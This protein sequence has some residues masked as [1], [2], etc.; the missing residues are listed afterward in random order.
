MKRRVLLA[1]LAVLLMGTS[2]AFADHHSHSH[3]VTVWGHGDGWSGDGGFSA[4]TLNGTYVFEASGF[5]NHAGPGQVSLL[6][7]L[8]FDGVSA[9]TGNF[10]VTA[11][12]GGQF[13]CPD[14]FTT[15]GSYTVAASSTAPGLGTLILPF[16]GGSN[17]G[18]INFGLLV[19]RSDGN[20]ADALETDTGSLSG[21]S[22]C[23][24]TITSM[25]L[26]GT[27]KAV[28]CNNN[29]GD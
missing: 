11:V 2:S 18:S 3:G 17:T 7:T 6:G 9:V 25:V 22:I 8:T 10:I 1:M 5:A 26:K 16:S 4:A 19:A 21:V 15:G 12:D 28:P 24:L 23:G 20:Q 14:T 13:S 29:W 27:L